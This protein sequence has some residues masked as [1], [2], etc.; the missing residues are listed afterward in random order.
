MFYLSSTIYQQQQHDNQPQY[1]P[2]QNT[3][4]MISKA[5]LVQILLVD[6]YN[7]II[8]EG[9]SFFLTILAYNMFVTKQSQLP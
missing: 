4:E 7:I 6:I 1:S 8:L 2:T 5:K 3:E 9:T